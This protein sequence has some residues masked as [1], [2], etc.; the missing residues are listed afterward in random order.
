MS[1]VYQQQL[2]AQYEQQWKAELNRTIERKMERQLAFQ[3][4]SCQREQE[5]RRRE[6]RP[7]RVIPDHFFSDCEPPSG[8]LSF[9]NCPS[10][11]QRDVRLVEN[12]LGELSFCGKLSAIGCIAAGCLTS[13]SLGA[14]MLCADCSLGIRVG[15]GT[16]MGDLAGCIAGSTAACLCIKVIEEEEKCLCRGVICC[17]T[18]GAGIAVGGAMGAAVIGNTAYAVS[19]IAET[20]HF[21]TVY[22]PVYLCSSANPSS[23]R[24]ESRLIAA[25]PPASYQTAATQPQLVPPPAI[26]SEYQDV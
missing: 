12:C 23:R 25:P 1:S 21:M 18:A 3:R 6:D 19:A 7:I 14:L 11:L 2:R 24:E 8:H 13:G 10:F 16:I 9:C 22:G 20:L 5:R 15:C 26:M 4:E 17:C